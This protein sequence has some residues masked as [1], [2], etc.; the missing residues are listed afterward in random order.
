MQ[1]ICKWEVLTVRTSA[2]ETDRW[3]QPWGKNNIIHT[4]CGGH[5][6]HCLCLP[7]FWLTFL[8]S[9]LVWPVWF[10]G[11]LYSFFVG[12]VADSRLESAWFWALFS[13]PTYNHCLVLTLISIMQASDL[14]KAEAC[15]SLQ[16]RSQSLSSNLLLGQVYTKEQ[17]SALKWGCSK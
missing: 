5:S 17:L 13:E 10:P 8:C 16:T 4:D 2:I 1:S 6:G 7:V 14:L 3:E 9:L 12:T 15:L 11:T